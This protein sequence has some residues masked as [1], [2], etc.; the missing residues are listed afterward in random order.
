MPWAG[1]PQSACGAQ[2]NRARWVGVF[3]TSRAQEVQRAQ[4]TKC[5]YATFER[6]PYG[7]Q[8]LTNVMPI[9]EE[10]ATVQQVLSRHFGV[11]GSRMSACPRCTRQ[12]IRPIGSSGEATKSIQTEK[13]LSPGVQCNTRMLTACDSL[14]V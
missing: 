13:C 14:D 9:T 6:V 2:V 4:C 10:V 8:G 7:N 1:A 5:D 12:T 11:S 3:L